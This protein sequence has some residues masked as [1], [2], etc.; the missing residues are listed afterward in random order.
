QIFSGIPAGGPSAAPTFTG[1]YM[2]IDRFIIDDRPYYC[3]NLR[4]SGRLIKPRSGNLIILRVSG[5]SMNDPE[6]ANIQDGNYVLLLRQNSADDG[7]IVAAEIRGEDTLATLKRYR[8]RNSRIA[9]VP[10][11]TNPEHQER[12]FSRPQPGEPA[13][14]Q[15]FHIQGIALAV[16]KPY[17]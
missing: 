8:V 13:A 3:K 4:G 10:E 5:D 15:P 12:E 11:S 14:E 7:D 2:E 17:P 16:F 6:K 9:L 1:R